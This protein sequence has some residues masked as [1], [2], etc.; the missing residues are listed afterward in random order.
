[1]PKLVLLLGAISPLA[2]AILYSGLA[3][4]SSPSASLINS[5]T[6]F[7][8]IA[9]NPDEPEPKPYTTP[10]TYQQVIEQT[11]SMVSNPRAQNLARQFGLNIL[12]ITWEDTG[13]YKNSAVGPNISD[14]TIQVQH[15]HP[16]TDQHELYLMP[17]IRHPQLRRPVC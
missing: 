5:P 11:I 2:L 8:P 13:R 15:R 7:M 6:P 9:R 3:P 1:M 12:D 17:V 10:P 14:M 16:Q 4:A